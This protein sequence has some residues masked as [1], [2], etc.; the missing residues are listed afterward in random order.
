MREAYLIFDLDGTLLDTL[1]DL[2]AS[3]NYALAQF[4]L[5]LRSKCEVRSYLGNGARFL[6]LQATGSSQSEVVDSVYE[7]FRHHYFQHSHE[8]TRPYPGILDMLRECKNRGYRTAIVSNKPDTAV[9]ELYHCFF[10]G[11]IDVAIGQQPSVRRKPAP[12]MVFAAIQKLQSLKT[13]PSFLNTPLHIGEGSGERL[14]YIGDSE[15]DIAT[16]RAASLPCICVDW[17]FRDRHFLEEQGAT[18]IIHLPE[19][20]FAL[21]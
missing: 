9:Q 11:L 13:T 16:A 6:I 4:S 18:H 15:V 7:V 1:D 3:V 17:G 2:W 5:P 8:H 10:E 14:F 20:L 12:D 19:E 21:L